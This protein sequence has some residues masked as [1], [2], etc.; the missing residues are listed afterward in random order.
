MRN[1]LQEI[2]EWEAW[3]NA[4]NHTYIID[5]FHCYGYIRDDTEIKY[6]NIIFFKNRIVFDKRGRKFKTLKVKFP[7]TPEKVQ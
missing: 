6:E 7:L 4:R 1:L 3:P 5:G 2:T